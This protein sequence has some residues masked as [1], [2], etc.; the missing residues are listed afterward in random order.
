MWVDMVLWDSPTCRE[1][2][3]QQA[4]HV[5]RLKPTQP[6]QHWTDTPARQKW[7]PLNL[8]F[9]S[10]PFNVNP[11]TAWPRRRP[12]NRGE[13]FQFIIRAG[14]TLHG[15]RPRRERLASYIDTPHISYEVTVL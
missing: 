2:F 10:N 4:F 14:S 8:P 11:D 9:F 13:V 5:S 12:P 6:D 3:C 7:I 15:K 1:R